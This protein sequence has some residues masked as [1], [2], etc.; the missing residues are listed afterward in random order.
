M[1]CKTMTIAGWLAMIS[2]FFTLPLMYLSYRLEGRLDAT[3][4]IIQTTMQ[5]AGTLLFV[6]LL[7]YFRKLLHARF[8]FHDTDRSIGL[9]I[10]AG[11]IAGILTVV[12]LYVTSLKE[13]T[14][15]A[16]IVIL[17]AQGVVQVQFGYKL[18]KLPDDLG[19]MLK[20]FCYANMATGIMI[21]SVVLFPVGVLVSA[22][23]DLMLGTIFFNIARRTKEPDLDRAAP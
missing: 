17:V 2:A 22:I 10:K 13:T 12:S 11:V 23:S 14:A 6:A 20:P 15:L 19:G 1:T 21:A 4:S 18:L 8:I 7:L 9:M 5:L 3:A 16:V